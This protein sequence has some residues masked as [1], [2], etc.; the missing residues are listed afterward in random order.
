VETEVL[1]WSPPIFFFFFSVIQ[2]FINLYLTILTAH[3]ING[4]INSPI[5]A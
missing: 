2:S 4:N 5:T 3:I 1:M